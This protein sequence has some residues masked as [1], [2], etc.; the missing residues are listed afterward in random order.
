M[1][2]LIRE[3]TCEARLG[4]SQVDLCTHTPNLTVHI[5]A[6]TG[7]SH[8]HLADGLS[9]TLLSQGCIL[10]NSSHSGNSAQRTF[11]GWGGGKEPPIARVQIEGQ[12]VVM[13]S[14]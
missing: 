2:G 13:A 11:Q 14:G 6:L 1:A 5:E 7:F 8:V 3:L 10:E 12:L 9:N 4:Q